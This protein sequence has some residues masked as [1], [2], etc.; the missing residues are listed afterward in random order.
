MTIPRYIPHIRN[1]AWVEIHERRTRKERSPTMNCRTPRDSDILPQEAEVL[2]FLPIE[3]DNGIT[4]VD[5][6]YTLATDKH[7]AGVVRTNT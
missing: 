3:K 4:T 7:E 1:K 5:R 2:K 6:S